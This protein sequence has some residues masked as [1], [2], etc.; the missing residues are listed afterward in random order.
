MVG[1]SLR[2]ACTLP[3]GAYSVAIMRRF[4]TLN[5]IVAATTLAISAA[6]YASPVDPDTGRV[7]SLPQQAHEAAIPYATQQMLRPY[8]GLGTWA[9]VYDW[10]QKYGDG[11]VGVPAIDAM[12][13]AGVQTLF[14]QTVKY[15][16]SAS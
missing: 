4:P 16:D 11:R 12:A 8:S 14:I 7:Y 2:S 6:S 3:A 5:A 1:H 15:K 9:D 13:K 10:S